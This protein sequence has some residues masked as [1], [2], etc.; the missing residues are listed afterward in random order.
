MIMS[1]KFYLSVHDFSP[2]L[3]GLDI[4]FKLKEY[5]PHFKITCF[6]IP[7][8]NFEYYYKIVDHYPEFIRETVEMW[9]D[10]ING[11]EWMEVGIHGLSHFKKEMDC[12]YAD[13]KAI[14]EKVESIHNL[15]GLKYKKIFAPPYWAYSYEALELLRDKGY[16]VALRKKDSNI[17]EGLKIHIHNWE[18]HRKVPK[19][20]NIVIGNGHMTSVKVKDGIDKCFD[21]IIKNIPKASEFGFISELYE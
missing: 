7:Y 8:P 14:I 12:S 2:I 17:P 1:K 6:N 10:R 3:P 19:N 4:L 16:V 13:A 15:D 20:T 11:Y 21:N 9:T 18:F 5:Y